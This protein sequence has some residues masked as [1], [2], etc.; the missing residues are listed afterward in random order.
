MVV[1]LNHDIVMRNHQE[2]RL[3][4]LV[5]FILSS[6]KKTLDSNFVFC[7]QKNTFSQFLFGRI[8]RDLNQ[9][10]CELEE[11]IQNEAEEEDDSDDD[12]DQDDDYK[13][14]A[15]LISLAFL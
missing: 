15:S 6:R 9:F 8:D 11:E 1:R 10:R 12:L 14:C 13:E 3:S 2:E 4:L 7:L 5:F